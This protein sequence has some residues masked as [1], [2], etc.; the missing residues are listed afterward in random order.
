MTSTRYKDLLVVLQTLL[1]STS[2]QWR[3][4]GGAWRGAHAPKICCASPQKM[5]SVFCIKMHPKIFLKYY[6]A[7]KPN[8]MKCDCI[9]I[10]AL[11][12]CV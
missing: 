11:H 4:Q 10:H 9:R 2:V 6:A 1:Q 12:G 8:A 3:R 7:D 5:R